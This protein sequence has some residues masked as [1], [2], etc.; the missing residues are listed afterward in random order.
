MS[1]AEALTAMRSGKKV[2]HSYF[3]SDEWMTIDQGD[4]LFEDGVRCSL[5]EFWKYRDHVSWND[6]YSLF[7]S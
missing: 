4:L 5:A 2:Q 7:K 1:K 6:G 3:T